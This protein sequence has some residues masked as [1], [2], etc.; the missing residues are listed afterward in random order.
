VAWRD[1]REAVEFYNSN[2]N[3][4]LFKSLFEILGITVQDFNRHSTTQIDFTEHLKEEFANEKFRLRNKFKS[5][6]FSFLKDKS[7]QDKERFLQINETL[8]R[9]LIESH[10]DINNELL[11]DIERCFD[12][13]FKNDP[14]NGIRLRHLE[15]LCEILC[16]K[17]VPEYAKR[18]CYE[19]K[20]GVKNVVISVNYS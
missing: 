17:N 19:K 13:L 3:L 7:L 20:Y 5:F 2:A 10:Y 15:C 8:D 12:I 9:S 6:V 1:Y 4:P 16:E 11:L 14:F 18:R